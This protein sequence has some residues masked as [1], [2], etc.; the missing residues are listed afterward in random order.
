MGRI[1]MKTKL[2]IAVA[3][4]AIAATQTRATPDIFQALP[5][6]AND[7]NDLKW[8]KRPVLLFAPSRDDAAYARQMA[9][10]DAARAAL[11]KRDIVV[12][13]DI[14]RIPPAGAV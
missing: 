9:L 6:G 5:E 4:G 14:D 2:G 1:L 13:S 3:A 7:L 12:L 11:A 8:A 10:F